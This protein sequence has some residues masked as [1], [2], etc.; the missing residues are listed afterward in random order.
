MNVTPTSGPIAASST[1][2]AR[3]AISSCASFRT[4]Q[5]NA[6]GERKEH[7]FE[8]AAG[9]VAARGGGDGELVPVPS[10]QT[11]PPLKSTN[12]SQTRAASRI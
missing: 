1:H 8:I 2:Q 5:P 12:R 3:D 4:S 9:I 7:L 11:R 6:L 10:P